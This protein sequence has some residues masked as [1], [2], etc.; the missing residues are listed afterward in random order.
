LKEINVKH[1]NS[2]VVKF[3]K[4]NKY[5]LKPEKKA[6][7]D[8]SYNIEDELRNTKP[9]KL[10]TFGMNGNNTKDMIDIYKRVVDV[11]KLE[12]L[13]FKDRFASTFGSFDPFMKYGSFHKYVRKE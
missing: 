12:M 2:D 10:D 3:G 9:S 1:N 4:K 5:T 6:N 13:Y 11:R 7:L 8:D